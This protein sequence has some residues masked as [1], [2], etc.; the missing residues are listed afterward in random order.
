MYQSRF[1][2]LREERAFQE[3]GMAIRCMIRNEVQDDLQPACMSLREQQVKIIESAKDRVN[4]AVVG[5]VITKVGHRGRVNGRNPDR[6]DAEPT[7]IVQ[8]QSYARKIADAVAVA[9]L[10]RTGVDLVN[11]A[12][13][14]PKGI[15]LVFPRRRLC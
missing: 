2:L 5:N 8:A 15:C 10:E 7:E 14:P 9:V 12:V 11:D 6:V 4:P 3:P 13:L 1:E